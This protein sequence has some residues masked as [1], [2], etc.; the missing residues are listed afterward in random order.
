MSAKLENAGQTLLNNVSLIFKYHAQ[1]IFR[2]C[3]SKIKDMSLVAHLVF[4]DF[5]FPI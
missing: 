5:G 3:T 1:Y 4:T 2:W